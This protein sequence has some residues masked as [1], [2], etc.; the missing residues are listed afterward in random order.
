M[1]TA[2]LSKELFWIA[3][4]TGS[5]AIGLADLIV[6]ARGQQNA[7][8]DL[9]SE[10]LQIVAAIGDSKPTILIVYRV[11]TTIALRSN[12]RSSDDMVRSQPMFVAIGYGRPQSRRMSI[13][14][15][16]GLCSAEE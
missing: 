7:D 11:T 15:P 8:L 14:V 9:A 10:C 3:R 1:L 5:A 16:L 12:K 6:S 2:Y 4:C 13:I